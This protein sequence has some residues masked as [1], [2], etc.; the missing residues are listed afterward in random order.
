MRA[1]FSRDE[2]GAVLILALAFVLIVGLA[3]GALTAL[4]ST[5]LKGAES[6]QQERAREYG[7]DAA[8]EAAIQAVRYAPASTTCATF[9]PSPP[10]AGVSPPFD[11][12]VVQCAIGTPAGLQGRIVQ[13]TAC[14][15]Y[16]SGSGT[17]TST[18]TTSTTS[19]ST[20]STSTTS[21]TLPQAAGTCAQNALVKAEV[22]FNDSQKLG[23]D[24]A[25]ASWV[26]SSANF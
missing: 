1:R 4:T 3:I 16:P 26:V 24:V 7:A 18:T 6:L 19:T 15:G 17:T 21:T 2:S 14:P 5:N 9:P 8:V 10:P 13:F 23:G 22:V 25:V 11:G 12:M 20:T